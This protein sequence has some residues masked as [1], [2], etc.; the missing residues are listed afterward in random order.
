MF[1]VKVPV[2]KLIKSRSKVIKLPKL[3]LSMVVIYAL[4][5]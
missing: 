3:G 1:V 4:F 2:N 5:L